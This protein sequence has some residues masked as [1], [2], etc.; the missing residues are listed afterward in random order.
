MTRHYTPPVYDNINKKQG[1]T[2][3][4]DPINDYFSNK[5]IEVSY[6]TLSATD[7]LVKSYIQAFLPIVNAGWRKESQYVKALCYNEIYN[8]PNRPKFTGFEKFKKLDNEFRKQASFLISN[9]KYSKYMVVDNN[10]TFE[11]FGSYKSNLSNHRSA[12]HTSELQSH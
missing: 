2:M 10:E 7:V 9:P 8:I 1:K 11:N 12:E 5:G 3:I 6:N 4:S